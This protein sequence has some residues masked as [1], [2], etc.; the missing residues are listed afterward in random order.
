MTART[1]GRSRRE[2]GDHHPKIPRRD[3]AEAIRSDVLGNH[4]DNSGQSVCKAA[5]QD[6]DP[7][8]G[9][10]REPE[11]LDVFDQQAG[12]TGTEHTFGVTLLGDHGE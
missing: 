8:S 1:L 4:L 10:N 3:R 7:E 5:R 6:G 2:G 11:G 9:L 12:L